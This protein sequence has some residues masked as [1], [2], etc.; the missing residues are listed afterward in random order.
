MDASKN[1]GTPKSSILGYLYFWKHPYDI[2][3]DILFLGQLRSL[4]VIFPGRVLATGFLVGAWCR[5]PKGLELQ[6]T[7]E[8][9]FQIGLLHI[10][11]QI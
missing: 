1:R 2:L 5:S 8:D 7:W 11:S 6:R 9:T 3:K 10:F 4:D